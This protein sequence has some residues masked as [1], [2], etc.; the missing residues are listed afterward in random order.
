[1]KHRLLTKAFLLLFVPFLLI[2]ASGTNCYATAA[3]TYDIS[4]Q[5]V[6]IS[7]SGDY[8]ITGS[9]DK[10]TIQ[11]KKGVTA[12]ITLKNVTILNPKENREER[13]AIDLM[14]IKSGAAVNLTLVGDNKLTNDWLYSAIHVPY[15]AKLVITDKSTGS[16]TAA[17]NGGGAGIGGSESDLDG[18]TGTIVINGGTVHAQGGYS[19]CGIGGGAVDRFDFEVYK[20][21][22]L[23]G[24]DITING[25][26]VTA[27]GGHAGGITD[28]GAAGIGGTSLTR[29][30]R[31]TING[32]V[33]TAC[34]YG[35][36]IGG[37]SGRGKGNIITV[38]GGTVTAYGGN[39]AS[40][41]GSSINPVG[42]A[43]SISGGT[44]YAKGDY[45]NT[46]I[47]EAYIS[48]TEQFLDSLKAYDIAAEKTVIN[49]G[50]IRAYTFCGR[51]EDERGKQVTQALFNCGKGKV[52][53]I[54]VNGRKYGSK[55]IASGGYLSL[56]LPVEPSGSHLNIS[57]K[58]GNTVLYSNDYFYA[59]G[60]YKATENVKATQNLYADIS[61]GDIEL[62][63]G[64]CIYNNTVYRT[65]NIIL[66][67]M[68]TEH[69]IM[70][71]TDK[72]LKQSVV[73]Q[74]LTADFGASGEQDFLLLDNDVTLDINLKGRNALR[75]G[76]NARGMFVGNDAVLCFSGEEASDSLHFETGEGSE[77]IYTNIGNVIVYGGYLDF[78]LGTGASAVHTG[79]YGTFT[80]CGGKFEA[81]GG[82][83]AIT[84]LYRMKVTVL[85]GS[86]IADTV[87]VLE[88]GNE[89]V[90]NRTRFV[91]TGGRVEAS[92]RIIFSDYKI[93]GGTIKTRI[94]G[95]GTGCAFTMYAG[96]LEIG[97][98]IN[99]TEGEIELDVN[100]ENILG[101]TIKQRNDVPEE[102]LDRLRIFRS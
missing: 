45:G 33:V 14:D 71:H 82:D 98:Y 91:M 43:V 27:V 90:E 52:T 12:N 102:E 8:I 72:D 25:G 17:A 32:G 96:D 6:I 48:D 38:T 13:V 10:H 34:S 50:N 95:C 63:D 76:D 68:T 30:G 36:G 81:H 83:S 15:G 46:T 26:T 74:D 88:T 77:A 20:S 94:L 75:L 73:F 66:G 67:G 47:Y 28:P 40:G 37:E 53:D 61:K 1:M 57:V 44:V 70:V 64:G 78:D 80:L 99:H 19:N 62:V 65:D 24:G 56:F 18:G 29:Q 2:F 16:L 4:K 5:N 51:L 54:R 3:K 93:Y 22:Y 101:G 97:A 86:L 21:H 11:V 49:G 31:I 89:E 55:D 39:H 60:A 42:T 87:G 92:G 59:G 84:G 41:I 7:K 100:N 85:G 9:T 79:N 58:S 69:K 23:G 35:A